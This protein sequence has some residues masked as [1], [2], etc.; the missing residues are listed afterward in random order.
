MNKMILVFTSFEKPHRRQIWWEGHD[1]SEAMRMIDV[2]M[3]QKVQGWLSIE[4]S[5]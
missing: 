4:S 5:S 1:A 3:D 2:L